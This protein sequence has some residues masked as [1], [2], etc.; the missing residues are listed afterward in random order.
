MMLTIRAKDAH[1]RTSHQYLPQKADTD[2]MTDLEV[3]ARGLRLDPVKRSRP[4]DPRF[5]T[6]YPSL[7]RANKEASS[8]VLTAT[9]AGQVGTAATLS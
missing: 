4:A 6:I 9:F 5:V 7:G 1:V 2:C 3:F 8:G